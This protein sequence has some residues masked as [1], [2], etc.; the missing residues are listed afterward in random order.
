[1]FPIIRATISRKQITDLRAYPWTFTFGHLLNSL[2]IILISYFSYHYFI[3]GELNNRFLEY[4]GTDDYLSFAIIGGMV[5]TMSVSMIMNVSRSLITEWREGTIDALLLSPLGRSGYHIGTAIQQFFRLIVEWIPVGILCMFLGLNLP[6]F[7]MPAFVGL[8]LLLWS[9]FSIALLLGGI[10]LWK[11][12]TYI[13]QNNLFAVI[14]L[15][16]GF[17]FPVGFLP[18]WLQWVGNAIPITDSLDIFRKALLTNISLTD[19]IPE[20]YSVSVMCIVYTIVGTV[21]LK[22][23]ERKIV[24]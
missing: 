9:S 17:Q 23:A 4:A 5:N 14:A 1:M 24:E 19:Y 12:D 13:I 6:Y 22:H 7:H 21:V 8:L 10:M 11:R 3:N 20:L 18:A 15:V 2:Y 16:C